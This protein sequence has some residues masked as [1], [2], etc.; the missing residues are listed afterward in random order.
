MSY[1]T[2]LGSH[3]GAPCFTLRVMLDIFFSFPEKPSLTGRITVANLR[4]GSYTK[5]SDSLP[6]SDL[7]VCYLALCFPLPSDA[8]I[9]VCQYVVLGDTYAMEE[10]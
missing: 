10:E 1:L 6:L 3:N 5:V 4:G 2:A 8:G 9:I 7:P